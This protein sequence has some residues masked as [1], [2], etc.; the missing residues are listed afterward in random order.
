MLR[1]SWRHARRDWSDRMI[2]TI[3]GLSGNT[4]KQLRRAA[5]A[6]VSTAQVVQLTKR[7]GRDGKARPVNPAEVRRKIAE[8]LDSDPNATLRSIA[9]RTGASPSYGTDCTPNLLSRWGERS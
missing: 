2:G 4:I 1:R 9:A 6:P 7:Q 5:E 3:C 8:A